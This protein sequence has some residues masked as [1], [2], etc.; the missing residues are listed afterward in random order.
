MQ[1]RWCRGK[2]W[3]LGGREV[4]RWT[5]ALLGRIVLSLVFTLIFHTN[6]ALAHDQD[7][8][9]NLLENVAIIGGLLSWRPTGRG[10]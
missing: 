6:L 4:R 1:T 2:L 3:A 5:T 9:V 8:T 7:Q 10:R